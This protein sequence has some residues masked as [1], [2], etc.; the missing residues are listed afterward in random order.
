[1]HTAGSSYLNGFRELEKK[2][3][4]GHEEAADN[5]MFLNILH[6][7]CSRIEKSIPKDIPKIIPDVLKSVRMIWEMSKYY[8]T[9]ERM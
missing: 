6:E 5:L 8:N 4:E 2:I 1:M 9:S 3:N 7:P